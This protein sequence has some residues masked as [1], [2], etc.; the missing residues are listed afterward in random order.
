MIDRLT[1]TGEHVTFVLVADHQFVPKPTDLFV[2]RH[3][4]EQH[5]IAQ[6]TGEFAI[7]QF[8]SI[9]RSVV[10]RIDRRGHTGTFILQSPFA[11][12]AVTQL[13]RV[14]KHDGEI[15]LLRAERTFF[16]ERVTQI[17]SAL[18]TT[19]YCRLKERKHASPV[20]WILD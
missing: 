14:G 2:A 16:V 3:V 10:K 9:Y 17:E 18:E 15:R 1:L 6:V 11:G 20:Q 19:N 5:L 12:V 8:E 4:V 13:T 7:A